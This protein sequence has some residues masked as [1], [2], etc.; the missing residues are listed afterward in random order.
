MISLT[1]MAR[2]RIGNAHQLNFG[3]APVRLAS[4]MTGI[5]AMQRQIDPGPGNPAGINNP[6][7]MAKRKPKK[8]APN[9]MNVLAIH[10]NSEYLGEST[11]SSMEHSTSA[12]GGAIWR[13]SSRKSPARDR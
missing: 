6:T 5:A 10:S 11:G 3:K 12:V 1:I 8:T 2:Q 9:T 4:H 7:P 13:G